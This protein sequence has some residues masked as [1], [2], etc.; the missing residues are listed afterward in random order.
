[1]DSRSYPTGYAN[2][3]V[4]QGYVD[5]MK[6]DPNEA[7][8]HVMGVALAHVFGLK[9][10]LKEFGQKGEKAVSKELSQLQDMDTYVPVDPSTLTREQKV[11]A[12]ASLLF[13]TQKRDGSVK[14]RLVADGSKQRRRPNY[15]KEDAASPTVS[16]EGV[17]ITAVIEAY[18][19]R[20]VACFDIPCAYLHVNNNKAV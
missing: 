13:I 20:N 16:N 15:K 14:G 11:E 4:T 10:G 8:E 2:V 19:E 1:M 3:N 17:F 9:A 18:G 7:R 6:M 12:L 5:K